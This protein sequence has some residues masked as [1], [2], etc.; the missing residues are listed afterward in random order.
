VES[1]SG[2]YKALA[3]S[4]MALENKDAIQL[5]IYKYG[6]IIGNFFVMG[7]AIGILDSVAW[8]ETDNV[9]CRYTPDLS[10]VDAKG[11]PQAIVMYSGTRAGPNHHAGNHSV[12]I[13][14][15]GEQ[16]VTFPM[17][18][19]L[20]DNLRGQT[21]MIKYWIVR[22]TWGPRWNNTG[23]WKH[24]M[25]N[26]ALKLNIGI[27]M[28]MS[29]KAPSGTGKYGGVLTFLPA[30]DPKKYG[31]HLSGCVEDGTGMYGEPTCGGNN[32]KCPNKCSGHGK[33]DVLSGTCTCQPGYF[34]EDC[35]TCVTP[36]AGGCYADVSWPFCDVGTNVV[37]CDHAGPTDACCLSNVTSS[38]TMSNCPAGWTSDP[39]IAT[40]T[41]S[42]GVF[43]GNYRHK[44]HRIC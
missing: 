15:W 19:S 39:S 1:Y 37:D 4:I 10:N 24:A 18:P 29:V 44:C 7:D 2:K 14:G 27:G 6:P 36:P 42:V 25:S 30:P 34:G 22:N 32:C 23:Y 40:S 16:P 13:V 33:C 11:V 38:K 17:L 12:V 28:D 21:H 3:S 8:S 5:D 41:C 26:P 31:C 43:G 20:P 35:S 9:Y